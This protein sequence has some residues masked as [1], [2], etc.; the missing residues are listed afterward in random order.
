MIKIITD[1]LIIR[2]HIETDLEPMHELLSNEQTMLYLSDIMTTDLEGTKKDLQ[3]AI[4]E[5]NSPDRKKYFFA[6]IDKNNHDYIGEIGFTKTKETENGSIVHLGYFINEK[7]WGKG[8]VTEATRAVITYAFKNLN[9]CKIET[10]C[11]VENKAS[12][13]IMKKLGMVKSTELKDHTRIGSKLYDRVEYHVFKDEWKAN[14]KN[15]CISV[16]AEYILKKDN[17]NWETIDDWIEK[18]LQRN[19]NVKLEYFT[20]ISS[21]LIDKY[22][23]VLE[24]IENAMPTEI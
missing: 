5:A 12:E 19:K 6:I 11:A 13:N 1:R 3:I 23:K 22:A 10:G 14:V 15:K 17:V 7:Y 21:K 4:K 8:I 9:V 16:E 24:E 2:D 18:G 20:T